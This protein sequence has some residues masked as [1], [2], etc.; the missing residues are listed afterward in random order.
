LD[1]ANRLLSVGGVS[2]AYDGMGNRIKRTV[3]STVTQSLLDL[4]P[5]L[6]VTLSETTAANT[7]RY[8]HT[9][10]GIHVQED[11]AGNWEWMA[12]DGCACFTETVR[13]LT[14]SIIEYAL[15]T[16]RTML[17]LTKPSYWRK[18]VL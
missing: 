7:T 16:K 3:G 6:S 9:A 13:T 18:Q 1:R 17:S 15:E 5:G 8:L 4:Q 14:S 11:S 12:E 10:R 2:Y